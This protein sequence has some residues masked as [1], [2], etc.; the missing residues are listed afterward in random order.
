V[1]EVFRVARTGERPVVLV[2]PLV[3]AHHEQLH[4]LARELVLRGLEEVVVPVERCA[5]LVELRVRAEVHVAD[6]RPVARVTADNRDELLPVARGLVGAV[7]LDADVVAER[8][9]LEQVVPRDDVE[10]RHGDVGEVAL[11]R[12]RLPVAV[13]VGVRDPVEI[14]LREC[15]R[16]LGRADRRPAD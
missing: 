8:A 13:L 3:R 12:P 10:G 5:I 9:V 4:G 7:G 14:V 15:R 1:Q 16:G 11:D 6:D 2:A